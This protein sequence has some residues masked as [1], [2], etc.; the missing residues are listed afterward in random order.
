MSVTAG[1][2][3]LIRVSGYN[4]AAGD[5]TLVV[6]GPAC[7]GSDMVPPTPDPMTFEV[8]P[9]ALDATSITMT[10][11]LA[12]DVDSP[13]VQYRFGFVSGGAGGTGCDWQSGTHLCRRRPLAQRRVHLSGTRPRQCRHTQPDQLVF[14]VEC[15]YPGRNP[16]G[17]DAFP[18]PLPAR[19]TS[20]CCQAPTRPPPGMR[21]VASAACPL[22]RPGACSMSMPP[23]ILS[24]ARS[25]RRKPHGARRP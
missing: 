22:T 23:A 7:D 8:P 19:S 2:T 15:L 11:S 12:T 17:A 4:G 25:G 18:L 14:G 5:Y 24:Q 10:G 13:P 16:C 3:Y 1:E 6:D 9:T 20:M 21:F